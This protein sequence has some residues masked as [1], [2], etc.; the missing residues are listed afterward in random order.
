[1]KKHRQSMEK[2][3][4][5]SKA[6]MWLPYLQ[7]IEHVT[8]DTFRFTYNGGVEETSLKSISS[9]ML[10]GEY[11]QLDTRL[12]EQIC[13]SGVPIVIHKRN[14]PS[15]III[16]SGTRRDQRNTLE[17]QIIKRANGHSQ[18]HIV[19]KILAAKF[20]S[21]RWLCPELPSLDKQMSIKEMRLIEAHYSKKYWASYF[22]ELG[23]KGLSRRS[24]GK[25]KNALDAA[26]KFLSGLLLRWITYHH[27]SPF[28]GFLHQGTDY[29]SL[30]YD[31]IEPYRGEFDRIALGALLS[32]NDPNNNT[33]SIGI[34]I[35]E[36]K[37]A[38]DEHVYTGLTRQIVT[39]HELFHGVVL[40][41]KSYLMENTRRFMVPTIDKPNGG[42]PRKIPFRLYGRQAGRTDFWKEARL[43]SGDLE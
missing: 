38:L 27:L 8:G 24:D 1:M 35:N 7:S 3:F 36:I 28:H 18:R 21:M 12:I 41:L 29:P 14:I 34:V 5:S 19:R 42:R 20:Y 6:P 32:I 39:R 40:A 16:S 37:K 4:K 9:I 31:L 17:M 23:L 43:V 11:G 2:R 10:Y 25:V 22:K 26:S 33:A 15:P 30:V 13:L